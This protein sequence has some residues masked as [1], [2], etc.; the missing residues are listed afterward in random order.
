MQLRRL[1]KSWLDLALLGITKIAQDQEEK[2]L[3]QTIFWLHMALTI[4]PFKN[5]QTTQ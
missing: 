3:G 1:L 5:R 2:T 4:D